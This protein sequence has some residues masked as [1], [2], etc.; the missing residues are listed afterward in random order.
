M[1]LEA[2]ELARWTRFAAKGGIGRCT[3]T[4]D[5]VAESADDLMFLKDDEITVLLQLPDLDGFY[6]GYCEGVVGRF[7][8]A[9]VH[10]HSKLKKPVMAKRASVSAASGKSPTPSGVQSPSPIGHPPSRRSS[11]ARPDTDLVDRRA[12]RQGR[13]QA[14]IPSRTDEEQRYPPSMSYSSTSTG[15]ESV[16]TTPAM[17]YFPSQDLKN[18]INYG[19]PSPRDAHFSMEMPRSIS[20]PSTRASSPP[21]LPA[22]NSASIAQ[23]Y[24]ISQPEHP[25]DDEHDR[26]S[27]NSAPAKHGRSSPRDQQRIPSMSRSPPIHT[28]ASSPPPQNLPALALPQT[29]ISVPHHS[30][31]VTQRYTSLAPPPLN[32]T[33]E[34]YVSPLRINKRSPSSPPASQPAP[35]QNQPLSPPLSSLIPDTSYSTYDERSKR[36]SLGLS[37]AEVGIGLSLLQDLANGMDSDDD[38]DKWSGSSKY[39][40]GT[41]DRDSYTA[42][43]NRV[44][45]RRDST[46]EATQEST[47]EGLRYADTEDGHQETLLDITPEASNMAT[48]RPSPNPS[49]HLSPATSPISPHFAE[50]ERR[51]SLAPSATSTGSWEGA[52]DIYDDYRYSRY[53]I[54]SKMSRFSVM[55][56]SAA[57]GSHSSA[58]TPPIPDA[59]PSLDS[60]MGAG[61]GGRQRTDSN[62]SRAESFRSRTDSN[63]A[64]SFI[65][66][67]RSVLPQLPETSSSSFISSP[68]SQQAPLQHSQHGKRSTLIKERT[69]STDSVGS[70]YTQNSRLSTLSQDA[71]ALLSVPPSLSNPAG[72][73]LSSSRPAPLDLADSHSPL[74]HTT[75][76]S[77]VSST[78]FPASP[79]S[80]SMMHTP[81]PGMLEEV[82]AME[83]VVL[84]VP[85]S[86]SIEDDRVNSPPFSP[87]M[88]SSGTSGIASALRQ[89]L[90][91][92]RRSPM[93]E[94]QQHS[95]QQQDRSFVHGEG[96]G[97]RIV[98]E[99][100]DELPSQVFD[101]SITSFS[102]STST[103][104]GSG[105]GTRVLN[106]SPSPEPSPSSSPEPDLMLRTHLAPLMVANRTPSPSILEGASDD[107]A[108][109]VINIPGQPRP[110]EPSSPMVPTHPPLAMSNP[111]TPPPPANAG[112]FSSSATIEMSP[113]STPPS[114]LRPSLADLRE[115][116]GPQLP[117]TNQRRSLFLP[118]PNA[119]KA[120]VGAP[121]QGPM[122]I[123]A[124]GQQAPPPQW[125]GHGP[126]QGLQGM[127]GGMPPRPHVVGVI[128]MALSAPRGGALPPGVRP[129]PM[130]GPTIYGRTEGD[131]AGA[132]G[133]V[134]ILFSVD[135]PPATAPPPS[136]YAA[137][138][139]PAS[140]PRVQMMS[141][142]QHHVQHPPRSMSLGPRDTAVL[143]SALSAGGSSL[144]VTGVGGGAAEG[145][146]LATDQK[147]A[148]GAIPRANF[149]PKAA[150]LRPRS[151][152]F[153]GFN[154]TNAEVPL[155]IQR[156]REEAE[157]PS[158]RE[159]QRSLSISVSLPSTLSPSP[160][161]GSSKAATK[162]SPLRPSPLSLPQN[163]V[164]GGGLRPGG[165][166]PALK[167]PSSP[168][169]QSVSIPSPNPN[170]SSS[171]LPSSPSFSVISNRPQH[172]LRQI[173][174]RS[175]L[176]ESISRPIPVSR[177]TL[178]ASGISDPQPTSSPLAIRKASIQLSRDAKNGSTSPVPRADAD[179]ASI[180]STRSQL[181]SPPPLGR[182]NSLRSKLSLPNLRR[183]RS[184]QDEDSSLGS[185]S[186][187]ETEMLQVQDMEFELVKPNFAQFQAARTS[188]DSGVLGRDNSLDLRQDGNAFLRPESP[189]VSVSSAGMSGTRSPTVE[190][191]GS[192]VPHIVTPNANTRTTE[193]ETS[194]DA[195][196]QRES[197]WMSLMSS[198]PASQARK[199][200]KVKKLIMEGVPSSVR[201]L[202]WTYLTD[203]KARC[204]PGVY[205]QLCGRGRVSSSVDI[206][207]DIKVCFQDQPHLQ[208]TQ[209]P[210][211]LLLQA[212]FNMVPDVQY[213]MGLTLIVGQL[214]LLAPEEDAFWIF[215]SIM[216]THIRP[217]FSS[218]T[219]QMEVDS[220]LFSRAV[221]NND[222][223][224]GK[225]LLV[226]MGISPTDIC[227]PWFSTLFVGTLPPEY[228]NRVWDLF[229]FEGVPYLLRVALAIVTCCRRR[230]LDATSEDAVLHMFRHPS[231]A[232]LPATPE[233]F[234]SLT[235]SIKLKDDDIRKQRVK[236]EAQVKRQTQVPRASTSAVIS[237][238]RT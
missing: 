146:L 230:I 82:S 104:M 131:L 214:L 7:A 198:N 224:I 120:P 43:I 90:E 12:S 84:S 176:N 44:G 140:P 4:C 42:A 126:Q 51:P 5:C 98:I 59:R 47:V 39:S 215:V 177:S 50:R 54:A 19:T 201:Y 15:T 116:G 64:R 113:S 124:Q 81:M 181:V 88:S 128:R 3:A 206:E 162:L 33:S 55:G 142:Q 23:K 207:K 167:S 117:G 220:A 172:Q 204:V 231:Q 69:M 121:T 22:S 95:H 125:Q 166:S 168:L 105:L 86:G 37:S 108:S 13:I 76:G 135:P 1:G 143:T 184:R 115:G 85:S 93:P 18:T 232:W 17:A 205:G 158:A 228:L 208:V 20:M 200:K 10:F 111:S 49:D 217:Y 174:S 197:K 61:L 186:H 2:A 101:N 210:V 6:L 73:G 148:G 63:N 211:L 97:N 229:L 74:L 89:R 170:L 14:H 136:T 235:L 25:P 203:G 58:P 40:A 87:T 180:H 175:T 155:P 194:M 11:S 28:I 36:L 52:S 56:G 80:S 213:S 221:E 29:S 92:D 141:K 96:L 183:N 222:S 46:D 134:P 106:E 8:G 165:T 147:P 91:T 16:V 234:I 72:L 102:S 139:G 68:G 195:H 110:S 114:H 57:G 21:T 173:T 238:P 78:G 160:A 191:S 196:R 182:Q 41:P 212:Y 145:T 94:Q 62:K 227:Q 79:K 75:W 109:G 209:G 237:L 132:A 163:S 216:D 151:R 188:E 236:M 223:H 27:S 192:W 118:H 119:P 26:A 34:S 171:P 187:Q 149:F 127:R 161:S 35:Y 157:I 193:S 129:A 202:V 185:G 156:S 189:A 100:E 154:S 199:S 99:D 226:D 67:P 178:P 130:R 219:T 53:S 107:G 30:E 190:G 112:T 137:H 65:E 164:T 144:G 133:P 77:P 122:Y 225:K 70:V 66:S 60:G 218:T 103:E 31:P 9:D 38:E 152:S 48:R 153:S 123:A 159:I 179:A 71:V 24:T 233:H 169:A 138:H 83:G 32:L 150:G 45:Q